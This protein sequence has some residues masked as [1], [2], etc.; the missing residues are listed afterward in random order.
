M[1]KLKY[2]DHLH[3]LVEVKHYSNSK[4]YYQINFFDSKWFFEVP[5]LIKLMPLREE[6]VII[7][8]H[9]SRVIVNQLN[10]YY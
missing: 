7:I 1:D 10:S 9:M 6:F 5:M 8:R 3:D 4:S 2:I